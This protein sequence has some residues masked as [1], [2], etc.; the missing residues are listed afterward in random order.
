MFTGSSGSCRG[1]RTTRRKR[2]QGKAARTGVVY[3]KLMRRG[4]SA[5]LSAFSEMVRRLSSLVTC[6]RIVFSNREK[7]APKVL[8]GKPAPLG[9]RDLPESRVQ[10]VCGASLGP[11]WASELTDAIVFRKHVLFLKKKKKWPRKIFMSAL[12]HKLD[13]HVLGESGNLM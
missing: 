10:R 8:L 5:Y 9:L 13:V 3:A 6:A 4:L 7:Q 2:C 12:F 1:R 11:W